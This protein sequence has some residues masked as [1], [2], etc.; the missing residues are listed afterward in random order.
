MG[1]GAFRCA[2]ATGQAPTTVWM[3]KLAD[4]YTMLCPY[5]DTPFAL[6][7]AVP[8]CS[9]FTSL[10]ACKLTNQFNPN[11]ASFG[12]FNTAPDGTVN[13]SQK[14]V[15]DATNNE[16]YI[17]AGMWMEGLWPIFRVAGIFKAAERTRIAF[18]CWSFQATN[19][20]MTCGFDLAGGQIA[21]GATFAGI[22]ANTMFALKN[23]TISSVGGGFYLCIADVLPLDFFNSR[24]ISKGLSFRFLLDND[25]GTNAPSLT[26]AGDGTSGLYGWKHSVLP[27]QAWKIHDTV[28]FDDFN[29]PTM[30]NIDLQNTL[31]PG[32]DWYVSQKYF[33]IPSGEG[34]V[35]HN[36]VAPPPDPTA[37]SVAGS[38]LRIPYQPPAALG[39][40]GGIASYSNKNGAPV[41]RGWQ[42]PMMVETSMSYGFPSAW[43]AGNLSWWMAGCEWADNVANNVL[44]TDGCINYSEWDFAETQGS[45]FAY[46]P[47]NQTFGINLANGHL[48]VSGGGARTF[49]AN[50]VSK[51]MVGYNPY[52]ATFLANSAIYAN[53]GVSV[54]SGGTYYYQTLPGTQ[55]G[56]PPCANWTSF[57][58]PINAGPVPLMIDPLITT[59]LTQQHVYTHIMLS[60]DRDNPADRGCDISFFDGVPRQCNTWCPFPQSVDLTD[61]IR[62]TVDWERFFVMFNFNAATNVAQLGGGYDMFIDYF[63]VMQ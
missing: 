50:G 28:F 62:H 20:T 60:F 42:M 44:N 49:T 41:G 34:W 35:I 9:S 23:Q 39:P 47:N 25:S 19:P 59:D 17:Q 3:S 14:I 52:Q 1:I 40:P 12:A 58:Y 29:D 31:N 10:T 5:L 4:N 24:G 13:T 7:F 33:D 18:Q 63:K 8:V 6:G 26:Y 54:E 37:L 43:A 38:I 56:P 46:G 36:P 11:N 53:G 57:V 2:G 30:A 21:Y 32:F 22:G 16:H 27:A 45:L 48:G 61:P 55:C 51:A 15:E